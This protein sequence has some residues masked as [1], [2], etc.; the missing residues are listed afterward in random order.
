MKRA[1][2]WNE[3]LDEIFSSR[4]SLEVAAK[5][6]VQVQK[7]L[8]GKLHPRKEF[9]TVPTL[10]TNNKI[11]QP[12]T[13]LITISHALSPTKILFQSLN[14]KEKN[15]IYFFLKR[16]IYFDK[17]CP[18]KNVGVITNKLNI[19]ICWF[20]SLHFFVLLKKPCPWCLVSTIGVT[21]AKSKKQRT[22]E[23]KSSTLHSLWKMHHIIEWEQMNTGDLEQG[24]TVPSS[25]HF[26]Q[27]STKR[28][29]MLSSF[30]CK[31]R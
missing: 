15:E 16:G 19:W 25:I 20:F 5:D 8:A 22:K 17:S 7:K 30:T 24:V 13:P 6:I 1:K 2:P 26:S 27:K 14:H 23:L 18:L 21:G 4:T 28:K 29:N 11:S 31:I 3:H 10:F 9:L 12:T